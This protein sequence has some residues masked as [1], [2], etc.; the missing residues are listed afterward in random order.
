MDEQTQASLRALLEPRQVVVVGASRTRGKIGH[1]VV[2]NLLHGGFQGRIWPVN[3]AGGKIEGL[4]C[5]RSVSDVPEGADCA[6]LVVP[7]DVTIDAIRRCAEKGIKTAIIGATGFAESG[8]PE[9]QRRQADV[10]AVAA[11]QACA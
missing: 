2:R 10:L 8:T 4:P 1:A 11:N 5:F 3:P 9:G 6:L 7:A